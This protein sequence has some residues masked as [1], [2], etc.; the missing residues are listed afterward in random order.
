MTFDDD[1]VYSPERFADRVVRLARDRFPLLDCR[2]TADFQIQFAGSH[3]NLSNFYR[4]FLSAPESFEQIV[5]PALTTVVRMQELGTDQTAPPLDRVRD[6]I[7]P[8]LYPLAAWRSGFPN[9]VGLE[10]VAGLSILY[11]VDEARAYRYIGNELLDRWKIDRNDLHRLALANLDDY[12]QKHPMEIAVAA[13]DDGPRLL[14]PH[15]PNAYNTARLLSPN[16]HSQ[17]RELLL[18]GEIA[19]GIPSRDFFVAFSLDSS[20]T[21]E[22]IRRKVAKDYSTMDHPLSDRLLLVTAD[23]VSEYCAN[24]AV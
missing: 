17:L 8:M 1:P 4:T 3:V 21:T 2:K 24:G 6:R 15:N 23:G 9:F 13:E 16:F 19:V 14:M 11:V 5:L 10:W 22:L 7:M 18:S 12:F 20:E